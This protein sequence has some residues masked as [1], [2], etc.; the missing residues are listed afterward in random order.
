ML[1]HY[2]EN[3]FSHISVHLEPMEIMIQLHAIV[4]VQVNNMEIKLQKNV[5]NVQPH[6]PF[7]HQILFVL[8]VKQIQY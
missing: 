4:F 8:F 7:V 2:L 1:K 3:V 6:V 5:K